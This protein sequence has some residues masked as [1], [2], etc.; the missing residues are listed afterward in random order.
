MVKTTRFIC[1]IRIIIQ[2]CQKLGWAGP[3]QQKIKLSLP[4]CKIN[5]CV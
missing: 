1:E 5:F 4:N 2:A 3:V